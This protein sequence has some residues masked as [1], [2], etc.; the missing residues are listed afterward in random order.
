MSLT[1]PFIGDAVQTNRLEAACR[2]VVAGL[3]VTSK[4]EPFLISVHVRH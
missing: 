1:D 4:V 2:I 3:D